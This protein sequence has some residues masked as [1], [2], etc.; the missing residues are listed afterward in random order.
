MKK[1]QLYGPF[2]WMGFNCIKARATLRRQFTF[3]TSSQKFLVLI[4]STLEPPS[5]FEP[6][7]PGLG[8]QHLNHQ[9]IA[10][11]VSAPNFQKLFVGIFIQDFNHK[12]QN[13]FF[14]EQSHQLCLL[15]LVSQQTIHN[16]SEQILTVQFCSEEF[17]EVAPQLL[18]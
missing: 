7:T 6:W 16:T 12:F 8:I 9:V 18:F 3:Y 4:L 11:M 15:L 14:K 13:T 2:L 17:E 10:P 1:K 5:G